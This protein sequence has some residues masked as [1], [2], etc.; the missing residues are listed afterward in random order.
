VQKSLVQNPHMQKMSRMQTIYFLQIS[1]Q[2]VKNFQ[3]FQMQKQIVIYAKLQKLN[4]AYYLSDLVSFYLLNDQIGI[5]IHMKYCSNS[6]TFNLLIQGTRIIEETNTK[7]R[8]IGIVIKNQSETCILGR[9]G[10]F[11]KGKTVSWYD[12]GLHASHQPNIDRIERYH[13]FIVLYINNMY[14]SGMFEIAM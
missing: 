10:T 5:S 8:L 12:N 1:Y 2:L 13:S 6:S 14:P 9:N 7:D 11:F 4:S 3:L